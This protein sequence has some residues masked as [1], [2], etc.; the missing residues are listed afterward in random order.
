MPEC[1]ARKRQ[2][3][4]CGHRFGKEEYDLWECP[5]CGEDRHCRLSVPH[6]GDRCKYHGGAS[7]KGIMSPHFVHGKYTKYMPDRLAERYQQAEQDDEL[8]NL[9]S[10]IALL[11]ARLTD[12]LSDVETA[13]SAE[14][15]LELGAAFESLR[16]AL[17]KQDAR[18]TRRALT[19]MEML[20][21]RGVGQAD[22][23]T[24]VYDVLERRRKL[25][26]SERKR[27]VDMHQMISVEKAL[28]MIANIQSVIKENVKDKDALR[29]ISQALRDLSIR[30][31]GTGPPTVG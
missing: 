9:R 8:L 2:C 3:R 16:G 27:L 25:I 15:W 19:N 6:E 23:W 31:V 10:D 28:T 26:E 7:P 14:L 12:L 21:S 11:Y 4:N 29:A 30:G 13:A 17:K 20:I 24:E 1:G 22:T 18:A 5:E